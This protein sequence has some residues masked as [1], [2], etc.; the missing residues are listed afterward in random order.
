VTLSL[1]RV[2]DTTTKVVFLAHATTRTEVRL[3]DEWI[4]RRSPEGLGS[5]IVW[6]G[7]V[8]RDGR[9]STSLH[10]VL[11]RNDDPLLLPVRVAWLPPERGGRRAVR[12]RDLIATG[13]PRRPRRHQQSYLARS[14]PERAPVMCGEPATVS[15]LRQAFVE[16][17]APRVEV[18]SFERFVE[19]RAALALEREESHLLGPQYKVPRLVREELWASVRFQDGLADLANE[20][21]RPLPDVQGHARACL[22]EMVAGYGR[23]QL[24]LALQLG[25]FMYRQAYDGELDID[26]EQAARVV[27]VARHHAT[28]VLPT[29]RSNLDA[30]VMPGA[31]HE[32][33]L[34]PTHTFAGVNMAFWPIGPLMKRSGSI[35]IRRD[36]KDDGVYRFVLREYLGYLAEKRFHLEW[37]IEG[38]RSRTGKLLPPRLG[39][40]TYVIDAFREGRTDDVV[41]VPASIT[42]D[43]LGEVA[44][45]AGEARG[46]AK[47]K[48]SLGWLVGFIR[49]N[50]G[51]RYGKIYVRFGEPL[52]LRQLIG[53]PAGSSAVPGD[54]RTRALQRIG[55]EVSWRIN[56]AT[57]ITATSLLTLALLGA[58][59]RGLTF[60]QVRA[61]VRLHLED[62]VARELPMTESATNL[63]T[64]DGLVAALS[65]LAEKGVAVRSAD[66]PDTVFVIGPEQHLAAA[67]YRN[68]I[69]H[70]F[71]HAA[72]VELALAGAAELQVDD[73]VAEF[74]QAAYRLRD[75]LKFDFF[76]RERDEFRAAIE[77]E[78]SRHDPA[79]KERLAAGADVD[80][81]LARRSP[82]LA[83]LTLRSFVEAYSTVAAELVRR[84]EG[85]V[86]DE[87]EFV[88]ACEGHGRQ[89]LLQKLIQSPE[90]VSR[91]LFQTG[92]Q[93]VEHLGLTHGGP[94][95]AVARKEFAGEL[96]TLLHRLDVVEGIAL[97]SFRRLLAGPIPSED[98]NDE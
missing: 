62:S 14:D 87:E 39:L 67:F 33:G 69:V 49:A 24:D 21:G 48:E 42:Y 40:L 46:E 68:S 55:F 72:I 9:V 57:P 63:R 64:D 79:W 74:W 23:S 44:E 77:A 80:E 13:N 17:I 18:E 75:L 22:D 59:G 43:Q 93:L 51:Q 92:V 47:R 95:V 85:P 11:V 89:R 88:R 96:R 58:L 37:Y 90:S 26:S 65:A 53:P 36:T 56:D 60:A 15:E 20:L 7:P 32:L 34:P 12:L 38:G 97:H 98:T 52:S 6:T 35:F 73:A 16:T 8:G 70:H 82:L 91:Q 61:A 71:L 66:G 78:L 25:R 30:G 86:V 4:A 45:F 81:L 29:H 10:D 1:P 94:E 84:D 31:W 83:P 19:R 54:E 5:E 41:L 50:R 28:V 2:P 3:L 27:A 76:F